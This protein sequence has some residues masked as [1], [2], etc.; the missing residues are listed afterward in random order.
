M[1]RL[2]AHD[3]ILDGELT[4]ASTASTQYHVFDI[5]WLDG[6]DV[7]GLPLTERR[8]L[9]DGLALEAPLHCA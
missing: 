1:E 9:L 3:L 5:M 6:R 4:W 2:H 7:T 8:T